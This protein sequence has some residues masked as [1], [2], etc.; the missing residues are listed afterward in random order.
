M[1]KVTYV[2][3][4]GAAHV[5][6][7]PVGVSLMRGALDNGV[8]GIVGECGGQMACGTCHCYLDEPWLTLSGP[9]SAFEEG[10]LA[11]SDNTRPNS[12]LACQ[13]KASEALEGI[14]VRT[15]ASQP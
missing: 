8:P 12:R 11:I 14:V 5:V 7:V 3:H 10:M 1:V 13:L 9:R 2:E 15:P 4:I 6:D